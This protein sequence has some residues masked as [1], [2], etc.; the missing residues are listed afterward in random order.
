MLLKPRGPNRRGPLPSVGLELPLPL[1]PPPPPPKKPP[2]IGP[3]PPMLSSFFLATVA[4]SIPIN[5]LKNNTKNA[6]TFQ[7]VFTSDGLE[8]STTSPLEFM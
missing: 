7:N 2:E 1:P 4:L 6:M 5:D 8:L 3:E